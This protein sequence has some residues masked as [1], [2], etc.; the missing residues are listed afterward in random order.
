M[1]YATHTPVIDYGKESIYA[2]GTYNAQKAH[3]RAI[4]ANTM[5]A[6]A[7]V[8]TSVLDV[9]C[10]TG[11]L[12]EAFIAAGFTNVEGISLSQAEVDCCTAK[13]LKARCCG[14]EAWLPNTYDLITVSHVLEHVPDVQ[15]FLHNLKRWVKP[16]GSIYIEVP[17]ALKYVSYFNSICQG[18]NAEH[19]NHFDLSHLV[20][21]CVGM[22]VYDKSS[23]ESTAEG[24]QL[25]PV[26]W[27]LAHPHASNVCE[28]ISAY[29]LKLNTQI[30]TMK[31]HLHAELKG[32]SALAIWGMG[33]TTRLLVPAGIIPAGVEILWATDSNPVYHWNNFE[34]AIVYPPDQFF[35]PKNVP[36]LVCS[37][38]SK[39]AVIKCI[40]ELDLTN[41][42]IT[43]EK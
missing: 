36:I 40:K 43:L 27:V 23:Y 13:G 2:S 4:V 15:G 42:I 41:R 26:I 29:A 39:D 31:E 19:I 9:G 38:L 11:G 10:A 6:G 34:D 21:A 12:M 28:A 24:N 18:F 30:A 8:N 14:V 5:R 1:V 22:E 16:H 25:Y 37:Q 33:Q 7:T 20:R 35:P 3:Y 17:N 32:V